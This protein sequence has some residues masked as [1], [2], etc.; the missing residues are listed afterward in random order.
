MIVVNIS[1]YGLIPSGQAQKR[2]TYLQSTLSKLSIGL[3][4]SKNKIGDAL[5]FGNRQDLDNRAEYSL[6]NHT[7]ATQEQTKRDKATHKL[8]SPHPFI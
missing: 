4:L 2:E 5:A 7:N 8:H 1:P 6:K 3:L